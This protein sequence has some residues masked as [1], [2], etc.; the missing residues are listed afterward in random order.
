MLIDAPASG[1]PVVASKTSPEM[2]PEP[3]PA[4]GWPPLMANDCEYAETRWLPMTS[5]T[6]VPTVRVN[7]FA[8]RSSAGVTVARLWGALTLPPTARPS[9]SVRRIALP[10]TVADAAATGSG[11]WIV[12]LFT[13]RANL[14][15]R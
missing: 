5:V 13:L 4:V 11:D 7:D 14:A 12:N 9:S 1:R 15:L 2:N 8:G 3:S 6:A 10:P